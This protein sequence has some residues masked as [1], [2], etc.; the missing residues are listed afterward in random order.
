MRLFLKHENVRLKEVIKQRD[1]DL[2]QAR[3]EIK[4]LAAR[5]AEV[6]HV[7]ETH[8]SKANGGVIDLRYLGIGK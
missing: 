6:D 8:N 7:P 4:A 1:Q 5:A 2:A 3:A